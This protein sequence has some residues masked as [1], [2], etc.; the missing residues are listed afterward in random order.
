MITKIFLK[1]NFKN[2]LKNNFI[3]NSMTNYKFSTKE[4]EGQGEDDS[5]FKSMY[6]QFKEKW[7]EISDQNE[8]KTK[9]ELLKKL[10]KEQQ[11][12]V[13]I[14][15][16]KF[17]NFTNFQIEY[18]SQLMEEDLKESQKLTSMELISDLAGLIELEKKDP[19][20]VE[21]FA[22]TCFSQQE[23]VANF[24]NYLTKQK[25]P[26]LG[27]VSAVAAAPVEKKVEKMEEQ[28]KQPEV[29]EKA[30]YDI[31]LTSFD[32]AKKIA[33]IKE[34]RAYTN[35]GLKESKELV[36]K[37]PTIIL[38]GVKKDDAEGIQ[39]KLTDNGAKITLI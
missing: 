14:L 8:E 19:K 2:I 17:S 21:N 28:A 10:S 25:K 4:A 32:Q 22:S 18:Y 6:N 27:L 36:E 11:E 24:T 20:I 31:E 38:K 1:R 3:S 39:K 9:A 23:F 16:D 29:K 12:K 35:L 33:L 15:A 37:A 7:N 5:N 26:D 13:E 30:A 34:V